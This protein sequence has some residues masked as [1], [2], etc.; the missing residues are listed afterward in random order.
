MPLYRAAKV[1]W[2]WFT[3]KAGSKVFQ[4]TYATS[5]RCRLVGAETFETRMISNVMFFEVG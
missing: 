2:Q 1:P 5:A 4:F 3:T